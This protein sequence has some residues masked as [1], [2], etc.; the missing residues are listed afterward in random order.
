[1]VPVTGFVHPE[2]YAR[3]R[4]APQ[5]VEPTPLM[6]RPRERVATV[7]PIVED[8]PG[9]TI[10]SVDTTTQAARVLIADDQTLFRSG[11]A[12]LLNQ[13]RRGVVVGQAV[14]GA[15]GVDQASGVEPDDR[16]MGIKMSNRDG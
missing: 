8:K 7:E 5:P 10:V 15:D 11:L 2:V 12:G 4:T 6:P 9:G 16:L 13:D 3:W 14:D 1:L